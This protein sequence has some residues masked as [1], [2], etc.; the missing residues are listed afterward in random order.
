MNLRPPYNPSSWSVAP[1]SRT[2]NSQGVSA[3][4]LPLNPS[5]ADNFSSRAA[6]SASCRSLYDMPPVLPTPLATLP[7]L[8]PFPP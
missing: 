4:P 1:V 2:S 5:S 8:V 3:L 7:L 6:N